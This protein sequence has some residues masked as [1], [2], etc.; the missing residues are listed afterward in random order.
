MLLPGGVGLGALGGLLV[1][2]LPSVALARGLEIVMRNS[3]FR[4]ATELLFSPVSL[5]ERRATKPIIDV[6]AARIGDIAGAGIVQLALLTAPARVAALL[7]GATVAL[8]AGALEVARRL[9]R[10]YL[11]AWSEGSRQGRLSWRGLMTSLPPCSRPPGPSTCPCFEPSRLGQPRP[12]PW[13][14]PIRLHDPGL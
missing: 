10:G 7:L 3:F 9:Q 2:G 14:P 8:A 13:R 12:T 6:G 5:S 1:P 11:D 4:S